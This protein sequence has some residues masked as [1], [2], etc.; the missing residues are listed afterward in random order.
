MDWYYKNGKKNPSLNQILLGLKEQEKVQ[1]L[2]T[3]GLN[4]SSEEFHE[5]LEG[6]QEAWQSY[7]DELGAIIKY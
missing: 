1:Q 2:L 4:P 3:S 6:L 7:F 5:A